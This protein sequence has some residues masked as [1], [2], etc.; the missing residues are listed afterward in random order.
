MSFNISCELSLNLGVQ[1]YLVGLWFSLRTHASQIWQNAQIPH[2]QGAAHRPAA[3]QGLN[4]RASI[5]QRVLPAKWTG[6]PLQTPSIGARHASGKRDSIPPMTLPQTMSSADF[7]RAV[8]AT[9]VIPIHHP[10]QT[11]HVREVS[12]SKGEEA[13]GGGHDAPNWSRTKS[14]GVLMGCT[15]LYAVIAGRVYISLIVS[16]VADTACLTE[17][18]VDVVDVVLDGS[19]IPEKFL[20][21]TLFALVPNTTEFMNAISFAINGNIALR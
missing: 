12:H 9:T 5:Y 19:G 16:A 6:T 18:L 17:I 4:E 7:H 1:S 21:V 11:S 2:E 15:A 8:E 13:E 20:G 10:R 14:A 3:S